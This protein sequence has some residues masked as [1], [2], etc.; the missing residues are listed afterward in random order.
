MNPD[1]RTDEE[2]NAIIGQWHTGQLFTIQKRGLYYRP[3]GNG[4]TGNVDEAWCLPLDD[5]KKHEYNPKGC[6][7]PVLLVAIPWKDYT[8]DLN[9]CH[10]AEMRLFRQ[11]E[12]EAGD[13]HVRRKYL[14][15]L[16][17]ITGDQWNTV[18]ATARQR[19]EAL[20]RVIEQQKGQG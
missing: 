13:P 12:G 11:G 14:H 3:N 4:Y 5:A 8:Q 17:A 18:S 9:A 7:E 6:D 15:A 10:E 16:D 20:V 2:L 1:K 19:A